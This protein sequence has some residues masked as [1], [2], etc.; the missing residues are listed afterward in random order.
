MVEITGSIYANCG[1]KQQIKNEAWTKTADLIYEYFTKNIL[2]KEELLD[3]SYEDTI[4]S[5]FYF[6]FFEK[7]GLFCVKQFSLQ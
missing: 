3:L 1:N 4:Q 2:L 6:D 5:K 7:T